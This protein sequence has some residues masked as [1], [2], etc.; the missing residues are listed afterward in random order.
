LLGVDEQP[1]EIAGGGPVTATV[2]RAIA[3]R[4]HG[5]QWRF[6][7]LDQHGRL[8]S[9]GVTRY[10]PDRL[11]ALV[12]G[13]GGG[14]E[15]HAP[16]AL[17]ERPDLTDTHPAWAKLLTDLT[18]QHAQQQPIEQDPAAR[19]ANRPLRRRS[20]LSFQRCVFAGCRRPA[21]DC[22][23]D[24]RHDHAHAQQRSAG[25]NRQQRERA[26]PLGRDDNSET[27]GRR[28]SI[29][30]LGRRHVVQID[31][32]APPLPAP[33]PRPLPRDIVLPDLDNPEP[34]FQALTQRGRPLTPTTQPAAAAASDSESDSDPPPF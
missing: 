14:V 24:H 21:A 26:P 11:R 31:P 20:Q 6:A 12:Q 28:G 15:L 8:L 33:K 23:L 7:V 16:A 13:V 19:F 5:A 10:R 30:P 17:L 22:D 32:I 4:Q 9:D 18:R 25:T 27:S 3:A 1:G 2:A 34:T 29:S